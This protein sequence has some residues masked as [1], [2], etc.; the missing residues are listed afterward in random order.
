MSL[1]YPGTAG[2]RGCAGEECPVRTCGDAPVQKWEVWWGNFPSLCIL[3][4]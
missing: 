1:P 3:K 2:R 4:D